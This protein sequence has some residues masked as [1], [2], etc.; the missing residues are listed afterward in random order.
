MP[1]IHIRILIKILIHQL[2]YLV[3]T[4]VTKA[5]SIFRI[6]DLILTLDQY[7]II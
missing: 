3:F 1:T 5:R 4:P 2:V 7:G 6:G